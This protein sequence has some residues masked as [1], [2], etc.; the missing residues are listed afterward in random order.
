MLGYYYDEDEIN[1]FCEGKLKQLKT[2]NVSLAEAKKQINTSRILIRQLIEND[3]LKQ[4]DTGKANFLKL[5]IDQKSIEKFNELYV[6]T[7]ELAIQYKTTPQTINELL[8]KVNIKPIENIF[9]N[10]CFI[11]KRKDVS[12]VQLKK[13]AKSYRTTPLLTIEKTAELLNL[14]I[15]AV[16]M[17]ANNGVLQPYRKSRNFKK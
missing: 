12:N 15:D 8:E 9:K 7:T 17:L 14:S 2:G 4:I 6:L 10:N 16:L 11:Y 3:L 5:P 1:A 13:K